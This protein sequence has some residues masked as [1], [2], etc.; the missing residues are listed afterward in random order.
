[1][2]GV[3]VSILGIIPHV[4]TKS[5]AAIIP[6]LATRADVAAIETAIIKWLAATTLASASLAF[7]IAKFVH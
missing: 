1:M 3:V 4:A 2:S 6:Q 5:D 7:A